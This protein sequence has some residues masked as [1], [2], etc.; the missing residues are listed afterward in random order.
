MF[1]HFLRKYLCILYTHVHAHHVQLVYI[2]TSHVHTD[3]IV[4]HGPDE[5]Y[6][7]KASAYIEY[8]YSIWICVSLLCMMNMMNDEAFFEE[9]AHL[10]KEEIP[11]NSSTLPGAVHKTSTTGESQVDLAT[12]V[13]WVQWG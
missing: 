10:L 5:G 3:F 12:F 6:Y 7:Q 4:L 1:T 11:P 13:D 8:I 9:M 2:F